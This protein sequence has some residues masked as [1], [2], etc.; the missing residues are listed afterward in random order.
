MYYKD[1]QLFTESEIKA[2]YPNTSFPTPF[3]APVGFEVC[4]ETPKP[5]TT[6]LQTAYQDGTEIDSKGNRVI[7]WAVRDMFSDYVNDEG[8]TVTKAEQEAEYLEAQ[9]KAL[10]PTMLTPRQAR[11]A[12]LAV[13]LLDEV[14]TLLANDKAMQ[15]WWEYSLDIQRNH[16]HIV[17]MGG[18][19]GLT[20]TQLDDLFI[21]GAKL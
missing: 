3:V 8:V 12:L 18:A 15:I 14:E 2:L 7:K 4:F 17:A 6:E 1:N 21:D 5:E 13:G 9:R 19:L 20:E 16:E 10:V 11:L